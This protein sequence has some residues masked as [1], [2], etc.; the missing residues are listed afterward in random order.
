MIPLLFVFSPLYL[1]A[2]TSLLPPSFLPLL[3]SPSG[4]Y[5]HKSF[6]ALW[7]APFHKWRLSLFNHGGFASHVKA[8]NVAGPCFPHTPPA[9]APIPLSTRLLEGWGGSKVKA[10]RCRAEVDCSGSGTKLSLPDWRGI[11][12]LLKTTS[13]KRISKNTNE[14]LS[15]MFALWKPLGALRKPLKA[16]RWTRKIRKWLLSSPRSSIKDLRNQYHFA[17]MNIMVCKLWIW[18][19]RKGNTL[20]RHN[21]YCSHLKLYPLVHQTNI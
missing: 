5:Q 21:N 19:E 15:G 6:F 20:D 2:L 9:L 18:I 11:R 3:L 8:Y 4:N 7:F 12:K 14:K 13:C 1:P 17:S 16:E 10:H